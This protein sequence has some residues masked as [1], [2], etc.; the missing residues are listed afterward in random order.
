ML[1]KK[2]IYI[3]D[4][5]LPNKSAYSLHVLK[6]CDAFNEYT[7]K[8]S[9]LVIPFLDENYTVKKIKKDYK[10]KHKFE[11][12]TFYKRKIKFNFVRRVFFSL[13]ILN[14][15][16]L[17]KNN[18]LIISR[19]IIPSLILSFFNI[20]NTLEIHTEM[21]GLTKLFF[22]VTKFQKI[23]QNLRYIFIHDNLRKKF[24]I[25]KKKSI[26][27][28]D[29]VDYRDFINSEKKLINN[30]CFYSGSFA[31]GKG[32]E[33]ILKISKKLPQINFHLYGNRDTIF[34]KSLLK[35]APENIH[36]KGYITYTELT[37][38]I[39]NY[40]VL[41]MPYQQKVGVLIKNINVENYFSPLKMF[42]Y[43]AAGKIII[44][45]N[46]PVY[47]NVL[48]HKKNSILLDNNPKNWCNFI[49]QALKTNKLNYLGQA[50]L[51]NSKKYSW[52]N[53]AKEIINFNSN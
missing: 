44:A 10:L 35:T 17:N 46:L 8:T 15:I 34:D 23:S 16:K 14:Y 36:F 3:A 29:A 1:K 27:L 26:I 50:A 11:I 33:L 25:S 43:L 49:N 53:R 6:I 18:F 9:K 52:I 20:K 31:R 28:I 42:D 38:R 22:Y 39:K 30:T 12:I 19:S 2:I 51:I 41:L 48:K 47:R 13:K 24:N 40:K 37:K 5:S 45:S 21:T 7:K 32:L 4:F